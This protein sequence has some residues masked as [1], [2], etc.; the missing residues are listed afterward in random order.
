MLWLPARPHTGARLL[1]QDR[2]PQINLS[3][4]LYCIKECEATSIRMPN[5]AMHAFRLSWRRRLAM[6][7]DIIFALAQCHEGRL[8]LAEDPGVSNFLPVQRKEMCL[9]AR[10]WKTSCQRMMSS[11]SLSYLAALSC[12]WH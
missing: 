8:V 6:M 7:R 1:L 4:I 11:A 12:M 5:P 3:E 2:S 9:C 10:K